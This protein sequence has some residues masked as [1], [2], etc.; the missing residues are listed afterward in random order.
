MILQRQRFFV[1]G[2]DDVIDVDGF[3]DQRAGLRVFPAAFVEIGR[4]AGAQVLGFAHVDD[5]AFGVFV[6]VDARGRGE[7][8]DF[9]R[10]I[11]SGA[12]QTALVFGPFPV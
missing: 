2:Y 12:V 11:H 7:A 4:D 10:E 9:L 1:I 6:E 5:F 8:A 3:A